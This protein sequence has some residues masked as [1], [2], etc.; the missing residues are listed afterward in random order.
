MAEE[1]RDKGKEG[2][3]EE[4][5]GGEKGERGKEEGR[6]QAWRELVETVKGRKKRDQRTRLELSL[7]TRGKKTWLGPSS[8]VGSIQDRLS[9]KIPSGVET[10]KR[11]RWRDGPLQSFNHRSGR[12]WS[13]EPY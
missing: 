10:P 11:L 9:P 7:V 4:V 1:G 8:H 2:R 6:R 5:E 12:S 13:K 3:G